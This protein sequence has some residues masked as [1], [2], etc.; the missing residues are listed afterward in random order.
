MPSRS[1]PLTTHETYHIFNKTIS[2]QAIFSDRRLCERT[3]KTLWF[4][5]VHQK[6]LSFSSY[7][8]L[9]NADQQTFQINYTHQPKI[10]DLHCFCL[11][12][13]HYHLLLTQQQDH[14]ISY[15]VGTLQNSLAHYHN[16]KRTH[17]GPLFLPQFHAVHIS[18]DSQLLHVSRYIHLNPYTSSM[19]NSFS[20]LY[21]YPWSSLPE[22]LNPNPNPHLLATNLIS[23]LIG[24][25]QKHRQFLED[26][27]DYQRSLHHIQKY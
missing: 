26:R 6:R 1:T 15:F 7:L 19:V 4:Y 11:M 16:T 2:D 3:L 10:I 8:R 27:A 22:Y 18:S 23:N 17:K 21:T 12:P 24:N 13:N 14:G 5:Q 25:P 20:D 9:S